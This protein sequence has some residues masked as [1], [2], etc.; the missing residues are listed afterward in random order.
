MKKKNQTVT[1]TEENVIGFIK[2]DVYLFIDTLRQL[3]C[4][5][6]KF[7]HEHSMV[8]LNAKFGDSIGE[9][10]MAKVSKALEEHGIV[11]K[12]KKQEVKEKKPAKW[13]LSKAV[14]LDAFERM[15]EKAWADSGLKDE[16]IKQEVHDKLA[17]WYR[18]DSASPLAGYDR[19]HRPQSQEELEMGMYENIDMQFSQYDGYREDMDM[20]Q[21]MM[22]QDMEQIVR[23]GKLEKAEWEY[24]S[25]ETEDSPYVEATATIDG[26]E[27]TVGYLWDEQ[28]GGCYVHVNGNDVRDRGVCDHC[29]EVVGKAIGK[30]LT[31]L[32]YGLWESWVECH[33]LYEDWEDRDDD[34]RHELYCKDIVQCRKE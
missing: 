8:M 26:H 33:G 24:F 15:L 27:V 32:P 20:E 19:H 10:L 2:S 30:E 9:E 25:D 29:C 31:G 3:G 14:K 34:E 1:A 13:V 4:K 11:D 23:D 16:S 28:E 7:E 12:E 6:K 5:D 21:T 17:Q 18:L 22:E